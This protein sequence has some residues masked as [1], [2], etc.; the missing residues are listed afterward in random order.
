MLLRGAL[1]TWSRGRTRDWLSKPRL[2]LCGDVVACVLADVWFSW[3]RQNISHN[4]T[5]S[6]TVNYHRKVSV[7]GFFCNWF[8]VFYILEQ[9][10][11]KIFDYLTKYKQAYNVWQF[12]T[13]SSN[14][15]ARVQ[16][17]SRDYAPK[18]LSGFT[19][20][21]VQNCSSCSSLLGILIY[22][23]CRTYQ[24]QGK[25]HKVGS[26]AISHSWI[27]S[28][29]RWWAATCKRFILGYRGQ[30]VRITTTPKGLQ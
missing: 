10:G 17:N 16:M 26:H 28:R 11:H 18:G 4:L 20:P 3:P 15:L 7:N 21:L 6:H 30:T 29:S 2:G 23:Y 13:S 12:V 22:I 1:L 25:S 9:G 14:N 5:P 27:Q 19:F 24:G 8:V